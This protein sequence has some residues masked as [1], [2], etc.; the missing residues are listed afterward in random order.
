MT[1]SKQTHKL[2][3][4]CR[5]LPDVL[6]MDDGEATHMQAI[7]CLTWSMALKRNKGKA[8]TSNLNII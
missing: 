2:A 3:P 8:D 5:K 6:P 7:Y 1:K 4:V